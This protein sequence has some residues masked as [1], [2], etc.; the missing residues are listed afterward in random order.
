MKLY[1]KSL[2]TLSIVLFYLVL[3]GAHC[4]MAMWI[5]GP[6]YVADETGYLGI[7]RYLLG[8]GIMPNMSGTG[9]YHAGYSLLISPVF[10]LS[11]DPKRIYFFVLMINSFLM[12]SFF[13]I[14]FYIL[15]NFFLFG[16]Q[17]SLLAAFTIC[18]YPAFLLNSN[19]SVAE[20]AIIP[21]FALTV[22]LLYVMLKDRSIWFGILFGFT[23]TFLYMVHPRFL[24]LLPIAGLYL[25]V[26][27]LMRLL[28]KRVAVASLITILIIYIS[29]E[30]LHDHLKALGWAGGGNPAIFRTVRTFLNPNHAMKALI[31]VFGQLWYIMVSSYGLWILGLLTIG[32][33]IWKHRSVL[34]RQGS[35]SPMIHALVFYILSCGGILLTSAIFLSSLGLRGDALIYGRY[36]ESFIG[37]GMAVGLGMVLTNPFD[38][39]YWRIMGGVVLSVLSGLSMITLGIGVPLIKNPTLSGGIHWLGIFPILGAIRFK[40]GLSFFVGILACSVYAFVMIVILMLMFKRKRYFKVLLL[41]ILFSLFAL[42][43]YV[44]LLLPIT[45]QVQSLALPGIIQKMPEVNVVSFDRGYRRRGELYRYQY[46]L[47]HTRFLFFNSSKNE[48]P[49]TKYFITSRFAEFPSHMN[50]HLVDLEK[51]GDLA[52][53]VKKE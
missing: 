42:V 49:Q 5:E 10:W 6:L 7:A 16:S 36:N 8:K 21:L 41:C 50:A 23:V 18:L 30:R 29:T 2:S 20:N 17:H 47:P 9:F 43:Q 28:P 51:E 13:F 12:S 45:K 14:L 33:T 22:I 44:F 32:L 40:L 1:P 53:W 38:E 3:V 11:S 35:P 48:F 27:T 4:L 19:I 46:F 15:K 25:I 39:R 37:L 24:I 34:S 31:V 26:L 52:L